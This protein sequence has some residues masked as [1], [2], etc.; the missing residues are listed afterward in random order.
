[1]C[2]HMHLI[3]CRYYSKVV[4]ITQTQ[5][6][7]TVLINQIGDNHSHHE[8][9]KLSQ[10]LTVLELLLYFTLQDDVMYKEKGK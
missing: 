2:T 4:A 8:T 6:Y 1:M 3:V 5:T 9:E 7:I 10:I